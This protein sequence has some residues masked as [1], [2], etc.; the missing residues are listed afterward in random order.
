MS[1]VHFVYIFMWYPHVWAHLVYILTSY[2]HVLGSPHAWGALCKH[3]HVVCAG[4]WD[5]LYASLFGI[6]MSGGHFVCISTRYQHIQGHYTF[7]DSIRM[8]GGHFVCIFTWYL[9]VGVALCSPSSVYTGGVLAVCL[10]AGWMWWRVRR[11]FTPAHFCAQ[12]ADLVR[13][14]SLPSTRNGPLC[15]FRE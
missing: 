15:H 6:R 12:A 10:L 13:L 2:P 3:L 5:T 9:H 7:L 1:G 4:L 8:S 11:H 14:G